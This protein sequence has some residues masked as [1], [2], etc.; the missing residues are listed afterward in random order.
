MLS[1]T[2]LYRIL[3]AAIVFQNFKIVR[4]IMSKTSKVSKHLLH[5]SIA[6]TKK[7]E[8]RNDSKW[9]RFFSLRKGG[10]AKA[11]C[12]GGRVRPSPIKKLAKN[13]DRRRTVSEIIINVLESDSDNDGSINHCETELNCSFS[14]GNSNEEGI[15]LRDC[16]AKRTVKTRSLDEAPNGVIFQRPSRQSTF[17]E[18]IT[19]IGRLLVPVRQEGE[20]SGD[21]GYSFNSLFISPESPLESNA[22]EEEKQSSRWDIT[23]IKKWFE[24]AENAVNLKIFGGDRGLARE[25]QRMMPFT[26]LIHPYSVFR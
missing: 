11:H 15:D 24:P 4:Y 1:D 26:F 14:E 21:S 12:H 17:D 22:K 6:G 2:G 20:S 8:G 10:K 3:I 7:E 9:H 23:K 18:K 13:E 25:K 19:P 5:N 16:V